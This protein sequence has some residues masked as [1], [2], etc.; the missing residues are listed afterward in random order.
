M[1]ALVCTLL[2]F[3]FLSGFAAA[4]LVEDQR[5]FT[6]MDVVLGPISLAKIV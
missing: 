1:K 2:A 5:P 3:W 4:F 6:A